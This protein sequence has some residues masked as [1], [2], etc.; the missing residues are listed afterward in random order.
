[1][2]EG[3]EEDRDQLINQS[4]SDL[5]KSILHKVQ[6]VENPALLEIHL[7]KV[8]DVLSLRQRMTL[9]EQLFFS[10]TPTLRHSLHI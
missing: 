6:N 2:R 10:Q 9:S 8:W 1:M 5:G 4:I 3:R 7:N